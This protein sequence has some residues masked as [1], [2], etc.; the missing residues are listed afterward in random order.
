MGNDREYTRMRPDR[1]ARDR[2]RAAD[3]KKQRAR[4]DAV[5]R[6]SKF[7]ARHGRSTG[8][9][10]NGTRLSKCPRARIETRRAVMKI[11][12]G[13]IAELEKVEGALV[14][15]H[16]QKSKRTAIK[17]TRARILTRV[18]VV[19]ILNEQVIALLEAEQETVVA[20]KIGKKL[21]FARID[22]ARRFLDNTELAMLTKELRRWGL[23]LEPGDASVLHDLTRTVTG[24]RF[25]PKVIRKDVRRHV[26]ELAAEVERERDITR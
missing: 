1:E 21:N 20:S 2:L 26:A 9:G 15:A 16:K 10:Y 18:E 7:R 5:T 23:P 25:D 8:S 22:P 11:L 4:R 14:A 6:Q 17:D 13:Q 19:R 3:A 24:E 12:I